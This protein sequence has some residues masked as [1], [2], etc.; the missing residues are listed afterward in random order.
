MAQA[1]RE[2]TMRIFRS[3][4]ALGVFEFVDEPL[5]E[6]DLLNYLGSIKITYPSQTERLMSTL[7]RWLNKVGEIETEDSAR[8]KEYKV[9]FSN[10]TEEKYK[11]F[12]D[13]LLSLYEIG[14]RQFDQGIEDLYQGLGKKALG[15][16]SKLILAS[17]DKREVIIKYD[18]YESKIHIK[19]SKLKKNENG[20]WIVD[21]KIL[22]NTEL[23]SPLDI[24]K[25]KF[26]RDPL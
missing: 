1:T 3:L 17:K 15:T 21:C 24:S 7:K 26:I 13:V 6:S 19:P 2:V 12:L 14:N 9:N 8:S 16:I 22:T 4:L 20:R 11:E 23:E 25:I 5:S 10:I 18:N